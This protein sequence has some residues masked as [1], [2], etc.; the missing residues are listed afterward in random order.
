MKTTLKAIAN[1]S[2]GH[3]FRGKIE[4]DE[5]GN[6]N[7]IQ[8][9]NIA[10]D[11]SLLWHD[12]LRT[13]VK[14]R[15]EVNWLQPGDIILPNRG[16]RIRATCLVDLPDSTVTTPHFYNIRVCDPCID[17][18]FLA[19]QINQKPTQRYF[20]KTAEGSR[21]LSLR[22][23]IVEDIEIVIPSFAEQRSIM[24]IYAAAQKEKEIYAELLRNRTSL[25][26]CI[27]KHILEPN[28]SY[29]G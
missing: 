4:P 24:N 17:P 8:F 23:S 15:L 7:V 9:K 2:L 11:G 27:A 10:E 22:K 20:E 13:Q 16:T 26:E 19:W 1:V 28:H 25:L 21:Q 18:L 3:P 5:R 12:V 6:G 14:S 29:K